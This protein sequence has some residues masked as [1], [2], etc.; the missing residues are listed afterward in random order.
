MAGDSDGKMSR[1]TLKTAAMTKRLFAPSLFFGLLGLFLLVGCTS[2]TPQT[3]QQPMTPNSEAQPT[4]KESDITMSSLDVQ[5]MPE[6]A[7]II[8]LNPS[9]VDERLYVT[10]I[11][12][13]ID[14][15]PEPGWVIAEW[16]G[17]VFEIFGNTAYVTMDG[18][19]Y[20]VVRLEQTPSSESHSPLLFFEYLSLS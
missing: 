3:Q 19:K 18:N 5:L 10:G 20:V 11:T 9:P 1:F 4:S 13:T 7:G 16:I 15:I 12:V 2:A 17:P 14:V 8:L 6:E